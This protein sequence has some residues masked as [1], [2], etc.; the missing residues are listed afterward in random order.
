V[1][2]AQERD[3][4]AVQAELRAVIERAKDARAVLGLGPAA[5]AAQARAAFHALCKRYHPARF[6]RS[7]PET[8]R[9]ANEAFLAIKRAYDGLIRPEPGARATDPP[10]TAPAPRTVEPSTVRIGAPSPRTTDAPAVVRSAP[11]QPPAARPTAPPVSI[12]A[13]TGPIVIGRPSPTPSTAPASV[14]GGPRLPRNDLGKA[15]VAAGKPTEK[16]GDK[17]TDKLPA[18]ARAPLPKTEKLP[19]MARPGAPASR[20]ATPPSGIPTT[21]GVTAPPPERT[22]QERLAAALELLRRRLWR[23][24]ERALGELA[25]SVP[26][27]RKYRAYR[28]YARGRVAQDDGRLDEARAEWERALRLDPELGPA[29][30]AIDALP[31]DPKPPSGGLLSKLFKRS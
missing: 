6:A 11:A 3:G 15:P 13:Q 8:V 1:P 12:T 29:R 10:P 28:H 21:A 14:P 23:D 2:D 26:T 20:T 5:G 19:A 7:S 30:Q 16:T 25:I 18:Q 24:A 17:P 31:E 9:L 27:E 4:A 22:E